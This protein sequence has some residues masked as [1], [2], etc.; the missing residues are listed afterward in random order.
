MFA[1]KHLLKISI[2]VA[3]IA[4]VT[5]SCGLTVD[6]PITTDIKTGPTVT[7]EINVTDPS[8]D[9]EPLNVS[10]S[11]GAG[12]LNIDPGADALIEGTATYNVDDFRP[13]VEVADGQVELSTGNLEIGGIPNFNDNVENRWDLRLSDRPM[14][15]RIF[16]G[17]YAGNL[18]LGGLKLTSLRV[19]DGAAD[20]HVNFAEPNQEVI[21]SFR[22]ETGASS[23]VLK[24]LGNANFRSL[25][26]QGGAGSYELDFSGQMQED[27]TV[28]VQTGLSNLTISVPDNLDVRVRVEEGLS[29][30][31]T[32]GSWGQSGGAYTHDGDGPELDITI[33]MGA[34]NLTLQSQ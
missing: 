10:I 13:E 12:E 29:N 26:F 27:A 14:E 23:V 15:L 4:L 22:Y 32:Q 34:G 11:F 7:E 20:V 30:I 3:A 18:E 24:N 33:K 31:H 1:N 17:A 6:I 5:M 9:E 21:D 28:L 25:T 19:A 8:S 16:A 2:F